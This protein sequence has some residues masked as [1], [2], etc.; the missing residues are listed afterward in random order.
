MLPQ[1]TPGLQLRSLAFEFTFQASLVTGHD[2]VEA[3]FGRA[4]DANPPSF[5]K[6][7][8]LFLWKSVPLNVFLS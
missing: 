4:D 8:K 5:F 2:D 3:N 6:N 1:T 7:I